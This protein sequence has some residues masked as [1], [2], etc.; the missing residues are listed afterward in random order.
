M[1]S[2][3]GLCHERV[4]VTCGHDVPIE[5]KL[6]LL[7]RG[8]PLYRGVIRAPGEHDH[9][10][11]QHIRPACEWSAQLHRIPFSVGCRW[12]TPPLR[13]RHAP[14]HDSY[15]QRPGTGRR[16]PRGGA[17]LLGSRKASWE[18]KIPV[19]KG[20]AC[21]IAPALLPCRVRGVP[22]EGLSVS[23]TWDQASGDRRYNA[24]AESAEELA[25]CIRIGQVHYRI[26]TN[27]RF[28]VF[29]F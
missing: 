21:V 4:D 26:L 25:L 7:R 1:C 15:P 14:P 28:T 6:C 19:P 5:S 27:P 10:A 2:G 11:E 17:L 3:G 20:R 9:G 12:G 22:C 18:Q 23:A 8:K 13:P 24:V 16:S 29:G